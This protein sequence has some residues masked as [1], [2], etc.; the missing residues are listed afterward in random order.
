[1]KH[2][3]ILILTSLFLVVG[4]ASAENEYKSIKD[5]CTLVKKR[6]INNF[7]TMEWYRSQLIKE[8]VEAVATDRAEKGA[9]RHQKLFDRNAKLY[10]YLDC[11]EELKEN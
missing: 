5:V 10:H 2:L 3:L 7:D 6:V 11:R 8:A 4:T 9:Q 1:M